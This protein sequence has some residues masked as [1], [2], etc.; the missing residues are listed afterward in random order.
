MNKHYTENDREEFDTG[1]LFQPIQE[2][3]PLEITRKL[4]DEIEDED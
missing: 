1:K 2:G 4:E 3:E